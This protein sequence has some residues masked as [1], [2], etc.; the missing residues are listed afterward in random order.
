MTC[1]TE[2]SAYYRK[3]WRGPGPR[4]VAARGG[5]DAACCPEVQA[6]WSPDTGFLPYVR[7]PRASAGCRCLSQA[8]LCHRAARAWH[9]APAP[10]VLR[11]REMLGGRWP[12][13]TGVGVQGA[14]GGQDPCMRPGGVEPGQEASPAPVTGQLD[15]AHR[16]EVSSPI[17]LSAASLLHLC[18]CL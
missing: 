4:D 3:S 8:D 2:T 6:P 14:L 16:Q 9:R 5:S 11:P 17:I 18:V 10:R 1:S 13:F 15:A 12:R 7:L